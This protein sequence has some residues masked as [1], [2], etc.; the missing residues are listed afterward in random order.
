M[1]INT[2]KHYIALIFAFNFLIFSNQIAIACPACW[3]GYG[4]GD[5]RFNKPLA[6]L[7]LLYE[8]EGRAALPAIR[9]AL[10]TQTDPLVK[11]RA[12]DYIAEL[13]DV[14]SL[15]LLEQEI[16]EI[17]KKVSFSNFGL[18]I[19]EFQTRLKIAHILANFGAKGLADRLWAKYEQLDIQ[20]KMEIPYLLNALI[21]PKLT[22]RLFKII[23]KSEEH[24]LMLGAIE[25]L[26]MGG[27]S[28]VLPYL[29]TKLIEWE[30]KRDEETAS[31]S[32]EKPMIHYSVLKIK[33][34]EAISQIED[35]QKKSSN[36]K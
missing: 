26:G 20:R 30:R 10:K 17:I 32:S 5:E 18:G 8:R 6:D 22:E 14:E 13:K 34:A 16:T 7:R 9:E 35:R 25:V 36:P 12:A 3:A 2:K 1:S 4:S 15:P 11:Q 29:R 33:A 19:P 23:D 24:Q 21:D 28:Q 27:D 31:D